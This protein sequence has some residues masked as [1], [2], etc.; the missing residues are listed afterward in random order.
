MWYRH[1]SGEVVVVCRRCRFVYLLEL[2][3]EVVPAVII[4]TV[5]YII[6]CVTRSRATSGAR[7]GFVQGDTWNGQWRRLDIGRIGHIGIKKRG[8]LVP[9]RHFVLQ[10]LAKPERRVDPPRQLQ[11]TVPA[12]AVHFLV[13]RQEQ[14]SKIS[15]RLNLFLRLPRPFKFVVA[16]CLS[17][18][19]CERKSVLRSAAMDTRT[20]I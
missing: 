6:V 9:W 5:V 19:C 10:F 4:C 18:L 1:M 8:G 13:A 7:S 11:N 2:T 15:K 14:R 16:T 20:R 12:A 3:H 17:A